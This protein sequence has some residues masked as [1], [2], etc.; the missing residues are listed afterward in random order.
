M[1]LDGDQGTAGSAA[2]KIKLGQL[3]SARRPPVQP[4]GPRRGRRRQADRAADADPGRRRAAPLGS[5]AGGGDRLLGD[6]R[7][8]AI[9]LHDELGS[10]TFAELESRSNSLA[11]ALQREPAS[12]TGESVAVMC[13]NHRGFVDAIF[14]CSKLG[15][16]VLLMNTDFAGPQ[17]HGVIEREEPQAIIY[18]SEFQELLTGAE[19][20]APEL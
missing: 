8:D 2:R 6:P 15:A 5:L 12:R 20:D 1:A 18:D 14:A 16:T 17:L 7:P 9:A 19:D 4:E 11:R 10:L 3:G 13:R